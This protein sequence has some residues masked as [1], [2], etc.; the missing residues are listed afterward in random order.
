M[1]VDVGDLVEYQYDGIINIGIVIQKMDDTHTMQKHQVWVLWD[2]GIIERSHARF[3]KVIS[4][5]R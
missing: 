3:L 4:E 2:D 1:Y 5:G